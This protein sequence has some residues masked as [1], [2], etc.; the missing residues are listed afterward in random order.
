MR[1]LVFGFLALNA[2][3]ASAPQ[4]VA[5]PAPPPTEAETL[6]PRV[7]ALESSLRALVHEEDAVLWAQ[8]SS[9]AP[10]SLEPA[11]QKYASVLAPGSIDLLRRY[12]ELTP[13]AGPG[14][15]RLEAFLAGE[16]LASWMAGPDASQASLE[17][18]LQVAVTGRTVPWAHLAQRLASEP[19]AI[20]RKALIDAAEGAAHKVLSSQAQRRARLTEAL[21]P[22]G[23]PSIEAFAELVRDCSLARE[24]ELARSFL[25]R[26]DDTYKTLLSRA[27]VDTVKLPLD[28]ASWA[29]LPRMMVSQERRA[30]APKQDANV[31]QALE[32]LGRL[33]FQAL[34]GL[35]LDLA[36]SA[37]KNPLPLAVTPSPQEIRVSVRPTGGHFGAQELFATVGR[38]LFWHANRALPLERWRL[39]APF[40]SE[41]AAALF[42]TMAPRRR[43]ERLLHLRLSAATF[44]AAYE[45]RALGEADSAAV[46]SRELSR[47]LGLPLRPSEVAWAR[48]RVSDLYANVDV[49]RAQALAATHAATLRSRFGDEWWKSSEAGPALTSLWTNADTQAAVALDALVLELTSEAETAR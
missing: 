35:T 15:K 1:R 7:A 44:L 27:L 36:D 21:A 42:S 34:P 38:A 12:R 47:A 45:S 49:L 40:R 48:T 43:T 13:A 10:W 2:C 29:D 30:K 28:R 3:A 17:S 41:A 20:K 24:A 31:A 18:T 46:W 14:L 23:Y 6:A 33:G 5:P 16:L 8:W 26:T 4:V 32:V 19:S 9:P 37:K 25:E 11:R 22:L 39:A